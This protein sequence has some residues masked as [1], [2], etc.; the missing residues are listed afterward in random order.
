MANLRE[1]MSDFAVL[2]EMVTEEGISDE[3]VT[4]ILDLLDE[5][6]GTLK[7]KV[8]NT[9]GVLDTLEADIAHFKAEESRLAAR[10]K[11]MENNRERLRRWVRESMVAHDLKDL[12]TEYH[13]V[14]LDEGQPVV[15]VVDEEA[16]PVE[17]TRT[18]VSP[19]KKKILSA[20]KEDGEIVKGC[21]IGKGNPKL[22]VR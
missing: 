21:E 14:R 17:Y 16:I 9:V 6:K 2:R 15:I 18:K 13:T 1:L 12:K 7:E 5:A 19:D 10:R 4:E 20:Y 11:T 3:R 8:D 22:V